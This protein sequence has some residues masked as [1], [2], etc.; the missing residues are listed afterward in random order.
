MQYCRPAMA[1]PATAVARRR[2]VCGRRRA[3]CG[4]ACTSSRPSRPASFPMTPTSGASS[5][6]VCNGTAMLPW[7]LP[8]ATLDDLVAYIK[9]FSPRWRSETPGD[10]VTLAPDP[11]PARGAEAR[12]RTRQARLSRAG[13]VRGRLPPGLCHARRD[14]RL[15][16]RADEDARRGAPLRSLRLRR[17]TQRLRDDYRAARL[18]LQRPARGRDRSRHRAH[19]RRGVGGTA[20]PTWK[21]VLPDDDLWAMAPLRGVAG[22]AARPRT[23]RTRCTPALAQPPWTPPPPP[24]PPD[25]APTERRSRPRCW[26]SQY[27]SGRA[28]GLFI[29]S[30]PFRRGSGRQARRMRRAAT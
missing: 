2:S 5:G 24:P 12:A 27:G 26:P 21:G 20:M 13:D 1:P 28:S 7:D 18:H 30:Y 15:H 11:W 23:P 25:A 8:E 19:D 6:T 9:T 22:R 16:G 14:L 3:T 29:C 4:S 17:Q 10:P